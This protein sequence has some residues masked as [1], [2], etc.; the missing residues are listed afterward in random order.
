MSQISDTQ[1]TAIS[2]HPHPPGP[3][4]QLQGHLRDTAKTTNSATHSVSASPVPADVPSGHAQVTSNVEDTNQNAGHDNE[5][6][7]TLRWAAGQSAPTQL[8]GTGTS[9]HGGV[10]GSRSGKHAELGGTEWRQ[11]K[12]LIIYD[13]RYLEC[14]TLRAGT[15]AHQINSSALQPKASIGRLR[16][17]QA[18]PYIKQPCLPTFLLFTPDSSIFSNFHASEGLFSPYQ[19]CFTSS[20]YS[21]QFKLFDTFWY[22]PD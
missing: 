2:S 3:E 10:G 21:D 22:L 7:N 4:N 8:E 13:V 9:S 20:S 6:G 16:R 1:V 14:L 19:T 18:A 17:V 11:K 12:P 15:I 5:G